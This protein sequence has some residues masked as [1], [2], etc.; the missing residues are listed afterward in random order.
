[1]TPQDRV[2]SRD[3]ST[4]LTWP[5]LTICFTRGFVEQ[6]CETSG[7]GGGI[8]LRSTECR[9]SF[10]IVCVIGNY[11]PVFNEFL[12]SL[13]CVLLLCGAHEAQ[14]TGCWSVP[15][16]QLNIALCNVNEVGFDQVSVDLSV[17]LSV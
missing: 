2:I 9:F 7:L 3:I 10:I 6:F 13:F 11:L 17:C 5:Q 1:M 16:R 4:Y 12:C 15:E 14:L 8:R